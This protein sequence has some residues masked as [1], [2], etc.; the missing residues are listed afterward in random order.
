MYTTQTK[1]AK[2]HLKNFGHEKTTRKGKYDCGVC[3]RQRERS[4]YKTKPDYYR[5]KAAERLARYK[6]E[7]PEKIKARAAINHQ[8]RVGNITRQPCEVC[9]ENKTQA[10][11]SDYKLPLEVNWLCSIH[12]AHHHS[13]EL[14]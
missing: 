13:L 6:I 5:L 10:H 4:R 2:E 3:H 12:H 1:F 8:I 11:H 7:V 14:K 9:G